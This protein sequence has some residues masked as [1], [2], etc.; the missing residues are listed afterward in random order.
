MDNPKIYYKGN[1]I[2]FEDVINE[3][4][5]DKIAR[6]WRSN[7]ELDFIEETVTNAIKEKIINIFNTMRYGLEEDVKD[8]DLIN[9]LN[10]FFNFKI[11]ETI[12]ATSQLSIIGEL[13]KGD[14]G[15]TYLEELYTKLWFPI[16][17]IYQTY[18]IYK[19]YENYDK[20][21]NSNIIASGKFKLTPISSLEK[22]SVI[23]YNQ[24]VADK[25]EILEYQNQFKTLLGHSMF[26]ERM[27]KQKLKELHNKNIFNR[28]IKKEE[29]VKKDYPKPKTINSLM[30]E[31]DYK[32]NVLRIENNQ[33]YQQLKSDYEKLTTNITLEGLALFLGRIDA[34]IKLDKKCASNIIEY[35][36]GIKAQYLNN[37]EKGIDESILSLDEIEENIILLLKGQDNYTYLEIRD[38]LKIWAYIYLF[39]IYVERNTINL[40]LLDNTYFMDKDF[41]TLIISCLIELQ[42][43]ELIEKEIIMIDFD[44]LKDANA[45]LDLIININRI[46]SNQKVKKN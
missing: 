15:N 21:E 12:N 36:S 24:Q 9:L 19:N 27:F 25:N 20:Y 5:S 16:G 7:F 34:S 17:K 6:Q 31:I 43:D 10:Q 11:K 45:I 40:M 37:F 1:L 18:K 3:I 14:D 41:Q 8:K 42:E 28:E 32:L 13:V 22:L 2:I 38:C 29:K 30:I 23:V 33:L 44:N 39:E 4:I 46:K 26:K 35:A